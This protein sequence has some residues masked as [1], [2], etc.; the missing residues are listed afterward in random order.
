[1]KS[2]T[3]F[4]HE[5]L[6]D[7]A[8]I[9]DLLKAISKGLGK[10]TLEFSD[11]KG[12]LTLEPQGLLYLKVSSSEEEDRQQFDIKVRWDKHPKTL[13]KKLPKISS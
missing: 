8:D 4:K 6:L 9:Q 2:K 5:A 11:D 13:S 10:G 3:T 7:P 12:V 1:M